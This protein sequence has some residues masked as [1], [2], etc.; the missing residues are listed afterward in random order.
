M[1]QGVSKETQSDQ[2]LLSVLRIRIL[3]LIDEMWNA[4]GMLIRH[5]VDQHYSL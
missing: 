2:N 1:L 5:V 4:D 3:L